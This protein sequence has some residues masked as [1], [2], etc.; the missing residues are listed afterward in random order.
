MVAKVR[1]S[2]VAETGAKALRGLVEAAAVH[3]DVRPRVAGVPPEEAARLHAVL[4]DGN[5]APPA[6]FEQ[7]LLA[8]GE[9]EEVLAHDEVAGGELRLVDGVRVEGPVF[10]PEVDLVVL[11]DAA[12]ALLHRLQD[13]P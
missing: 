6:D 11:D 8:E 10:L 2:E 4:E 12:R 13:H 7:P 1:V 3:D 5:A 9:A